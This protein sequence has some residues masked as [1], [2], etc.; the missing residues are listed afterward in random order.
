MW[1]DHI[2][3]VKQ[4]IVWVKEHISAY[5]GDPSTIVICGGSAGGHLASLAAMTPNETLFQPDFEEK[6]TKVQGCID[7]YDIT[8]FADQVC[9]YVSHHDGHS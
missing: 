2:V 9:T 6:D 5:G 3:D 4:A 1:P 7:I 8:D